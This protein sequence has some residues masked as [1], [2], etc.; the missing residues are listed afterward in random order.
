MI[1]QQVYTGSILYQ[2]ELDA[3]NG[4]ANVAEAIN[5]IATSERT[6]V[7]F[8]I[9]S[10]T[11][12]AEVLAEVLDGINSKYGGATVTESQGCWSDDADKD[13]PAYDK[14][15]T[16]RAIQIEVSA[17]PDAIDMAYLQGC[18]KPAA[19]HATWIHCE[20]FTTY[21]NHFNVKD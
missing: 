4:I 17:A 21:A 8:I 7:L 9:G 10:D 19:D 20:T 18:F 1:K 11:I 6:H 13:L 5:T 12:T 3:A 2:T 16:E 15:K 14:V